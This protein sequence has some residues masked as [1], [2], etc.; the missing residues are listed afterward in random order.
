MTFLFG[1]LARDVTTLKSSQVIVEGFSLFSVKHN[2]YSIYSKAVG[3]KHPTICLFF[4]ALESA[5]CCA[6]CRLEC[7]GG[8][9][10]RFLKP[11]AQK[12]GEER[13]RLVHL[14]RRW[15]WSILARNSSAFQTPNIIGHGGLM[16]D[17]TLLC[18]CLRAFAFPSFKGT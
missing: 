7:F 3:T 9:L 17:V 1:A 12:A 14:H 11:T 10:C 15:H 16:F 8:L 6:K 18:E 5:N 13:L 4:L 2:N